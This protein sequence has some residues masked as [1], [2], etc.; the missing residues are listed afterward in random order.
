MGPWRAYPPTF[1]CLVWDANVP[2]RAMGT[3]LDDHGHR[4]CE[5]N[6]TSGAGERME[7]R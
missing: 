2:S 7:I 5:A 4:A 6:L 3:G 1:L